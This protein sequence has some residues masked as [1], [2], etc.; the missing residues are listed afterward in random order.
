MADRPGA[1]DSVIAGTLHGFLQG[2]VTEG[3]S[4]GLQAARFALP[5]FDDLTR[6]TVRDLEPAASGDIVR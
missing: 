2:S 4:H 5:H 1:G 6:I 3:M